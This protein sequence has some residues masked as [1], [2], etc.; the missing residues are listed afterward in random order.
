MKE[1]VPGA[2]RF[3]ALQDLANAGLDTE[4]FASLFKHANVQGN[5]LFFVFKSG[6]ACQEFGYKK[7][8][9]KER[10][11]AHYAAHLDEMKRHKIVFKDIDAKVDHKPKPLDMQK[12][13]ELLFEERSTGAFEVTVQDPKVRALM[14]EI[15]EIIKTRKQ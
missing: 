12:D 9:I 1:I 3:K 4:G 2:D 8:S 10:M 13:E 5:T 6:A 7:E 15:R 11:R 14:L